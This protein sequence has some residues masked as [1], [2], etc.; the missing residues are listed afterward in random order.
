MVFIPGTVAVFNIFLCIGINKWLGV[1]M[2]YLYVSS[3]LVVPGYCGNHAP[4]TNISF[5][6]FSLARTKSPGGLHG[7]FTS[8]STVDNGLCSFVGGLVVNSRTARGYL[9]ITGFKR[10]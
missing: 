7:L 4:D 2:L 5:S 1:F 6:T 8:C 9:S 10:F 3:F